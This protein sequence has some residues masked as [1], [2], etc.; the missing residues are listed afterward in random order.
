LVVEVSRAGACGLATAVA[1]GSLA[2]AAL[3]AVLVATNLSHSPQWPAVFLGILPL[4]LVYSIAGALIARRQPRNPIGWLFL[5]ISTDYSLTA[6][7]DAYAGHHLPGWAAA[8]WLQTWT[9]YLSYPVGFSLLLMLFPSGRLPSRRWRALLGLAFLAAATRVAV[10]LLSIGPVSGHFS[11]S[12]LL[13]ANPTGLL[14]VGWDSYGARAPDPSCVLAAWQL[15]AA[16][17]R[18]DIPAPAVVPT[19]RGGVQLEWHRNGADLEIEV[20]APREF[21]VSFEAGAVGG[22][23]EKSLTDDFAELSPALDRI[24]GGPAHERRPSE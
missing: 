7:A 11:G 24:A 23:W 3:T 17:M 15:L 20:V 16:V 21:V 18:D 19:V 1:C 13:A 2:A 6:L 4:A 22:S 12:A 14:P 8:A 9:F 5:L 10:A